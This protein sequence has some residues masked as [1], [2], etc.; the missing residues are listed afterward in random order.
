MSIDILSSLIGTAVGGILSL[1]GSYFSIKWQS[2]IKNADQSKM[3]NTFYIEQID[4]MSEHIEQLARIFDDRHIIS[5]QHIDQIHVTT[6]LINKHSDG[7]IFIKDK[8]IRKKIRNFFFD[9]FYDAQ[10]A[11]SAHIRKEEIE[12]TI[13]QENDPQALQQKQNQ[14][15]Q[16]YNDMKS[17]ILDLKNH[18]V[19]IHDFKKELE[20]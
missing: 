9:C 1:V 18:T 10:R 7:F 14:A 17:F 16:S 5:F 19:L 13:L 6:D 15:A 4:L 12:R 20:T 2:D 11:K 3:Y 8:L